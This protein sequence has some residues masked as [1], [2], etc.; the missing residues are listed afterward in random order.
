MEQVAERLGLH[1]LRPLGGA[2]WLTS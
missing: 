2:P 1:R